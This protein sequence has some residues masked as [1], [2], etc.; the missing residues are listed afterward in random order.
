MKIKI[1]NKNIKI[2]NTM[3]LFLVLILS[4]NSDIL[5]KVP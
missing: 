1:E 4:I 5:F 3:A 2:Q